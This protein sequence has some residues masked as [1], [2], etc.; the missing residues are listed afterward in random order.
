[1]NMEIYQKK[2]MEQKELDMKREAEL[3]RIRDKHQQNFAAYQNL[4]EHIKNK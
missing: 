1:M 4:S 3:R 2:M